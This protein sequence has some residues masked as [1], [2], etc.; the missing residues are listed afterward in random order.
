[1]C[2]CA[3]MCKTSKYDFI[4][5]AALSFR[6]DCVI[7]LFA[8]FCLTFTFVLGDNKYGITV[9]LF[10]PPRTMSSG[11]AYVLPVMYLFFVSPLVLGAPATDRPETLPHGR[12]VAE[13]Y[14]L[15]PKTRGAVPKKIGGPKTCKISVNFGSLQTLIANISGT[16][17]DIQNRKTVRTIAI[18]PAFKEKSPV[19]FGPL[20]AWNY[21]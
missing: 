2:I 3:F 11:R 6:R 20:T 19:Y 13:F 17:E 18:P 14:N 4:K 10:R 9:L 5:H 7:V 8:G 21:M 15:T 12:N 1:M 16:A